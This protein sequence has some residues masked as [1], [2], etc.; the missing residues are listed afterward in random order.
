[1][2]SQH[3]AIFSPNWLIKSVRREVVFIF[4]L[5]LLIRTVFLF[6]W[7]I[8]TEY[9]LPE[10][11]GE[12][13]RVG[14]NLALTGNY[15]DPYLVPS[16][17]TAHPLPLFT[18]LLALIYKLFGV[19]LTAG[20]IRCFLCITSYSAMYA[21]LPW[22]AAQIGLER[23]AGFLGGLV[24]ALVVPLGTAEVI[25]WTA[26]EPIT[27]I[28]LGGLLIGFFRRWEKT[29]YGKI[30]VFPLGL[31]FGLAF[32]FSPALLTVLVGLILFE[33]YWRR[34]S[35]KWV[36]VLILLLGITLACIPW[37]WRNITTFQEFFFLRSNFGLELRLG[38][39]A[40]AEADMDRM[41]VR[42]GKGMRH[43]SNN[44]GEALRVRELGEIVYMRQ[45]RQEAL[46]WIKDY[47]VEF[48]RLTLLRMLYFWFGS[49]YD[50]VLSS[51]ISLLMVLAFL[52]GWR[53]V[54][55]LTIP[56]R[57]VLLIPLV[58]YPLTYYLV[59]Y[60]MRYTVPVLWMVLLLVGVEMN[61]LIGKD[62]F[63]KQKPVRKLTGLFIG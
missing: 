54:R 40:G 36:S 51:G 34:D 6:S 1:L 46:Q 39:H 24:G 58:T 53:S 55:Q 8:P 32:H 20:Y 18:G 49:W 3:K 50:P 33:L 26:N 35:G 44:R 12:I 43:P 22:F 5:A 14:Q 41:D 56:A 45:A 42:E 48:I 11:V 29:Q 16:G 57:A 2:D 17:P 63:K 9:I 37:N 52:G 13:G 28:L 19:T 62:I 30:G 61:S 23:K 47:P 7:M 25:G 21:M 27:A 10:T 60:M 31:I 59:P 15:A 38:N 4:V